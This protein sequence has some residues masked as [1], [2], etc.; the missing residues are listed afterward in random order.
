MQC[1]RM[2][3]L[4]ELTVCLHARSL[5][6]T[7]Y[8]NG[9]DLCCLVY[10]PHSVLGLVGLRQTDKKRSGVVEDRHSTHT[11]PYQSSSNVVG[12]VVICVM[13]CNGFPVLF[14]RFTV[15]FRHE[16]LSGLKSKNGIENCYFL[17]NG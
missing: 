15:C 4:L 9:V 10:G 1:L 6:L 16:I 3:F 13:E 11:V 7:I 2:Q 14:F 5:I 8:W 17:T 12:S